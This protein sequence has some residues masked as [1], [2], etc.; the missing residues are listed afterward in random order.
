M[1]FLVSATSVASAATRMS[2]THVASTSTHADGVTTLIEALAAGLAD[3]VYGR[4]SLRIMH[5]ASFA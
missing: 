1:C 5:L 2:T 3:A 4:V